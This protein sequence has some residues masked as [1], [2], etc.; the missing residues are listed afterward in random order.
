MPR[1]SRRDNVEAWWDLVM[2]QEN[3]S[4]GGEAQDASSL[5]REKQRWFLIMLLSWIAG[6]V[7]LINVV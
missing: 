6:T 2:G 3:R 7:V 4:P 5:G 1:P